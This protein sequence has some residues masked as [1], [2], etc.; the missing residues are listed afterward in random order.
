MNSIPDYVDITAKLI[1]LP[2]DPEYR[3]GVIANLEMIAEIAS[4]VTEFSLEAEV[5][6]APIFHPLQGDSEGRG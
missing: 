1:N 4:L 5:E 3:P 6:P 2:I